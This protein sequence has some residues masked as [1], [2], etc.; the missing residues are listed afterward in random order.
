MLLQ[1]M[2]AY[3]PDGLQ[4][5]APTNIT[6]ATIPSAVAKAPEPSKSHGIFNKMLGKMLKL[7]MPKTKSLSKKSPKPFKKQK[8]KKV[9]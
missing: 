3:I 9:I 6:G 2:D 4:A 1:V 8:K 5:V 7:K